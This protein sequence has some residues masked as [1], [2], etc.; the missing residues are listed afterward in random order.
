M[1]NIFFLSDIIV[2]VANEALLIKHGNLM[3][4]NLGST[5]RW[6]S[7][8]S[9]GEYISIETWVFAYYISQYVKERT[10]ENEPEVIK[11]A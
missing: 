2:T 3:G 10:N 5:S 11:M 9:G 8:I 1:R 6:T 4:R 7:K